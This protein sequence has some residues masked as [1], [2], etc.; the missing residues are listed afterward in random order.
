MKHP[1]KAAR[2]A[3]LLQSGI[4]SLIDPITSF[5]DYCIDS[6]SCFAIRLTGGQYMVVIE[7]ERQHA[8]DGIPR[9][10]I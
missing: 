2:S 4:R 7:I 6:H 3:I 10:T 8:L 9:K 1:V 5:K